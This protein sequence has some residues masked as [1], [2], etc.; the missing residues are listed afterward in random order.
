M[1]KVTRKFNYDLIYDSLE[2][3]NLPIYK[4]NSGPCLKTDICEEIDFPVFIV[5]IPK[6][7]TYLTAE[8]LKNLGIPFAGVHISPIGIV[9]H[10]F[11]SAEQIKKNPETLNAPMS[12]NIS[13]SLIRNGQ[14]CVGHIP[15]S[16]KEDLLKFKKIVTYRN[17][18]RNMVVSLTRYYGSIKSKI[19]GTSEESL[20]EFNKLKMSE[21]KIEMCLKLW[22]NNIS[23]L[24]R[25]M[26]PWQKNKDCLRISFESLTEEK[27]VIKIANFLDLDVSPER[28]KE[29]LDIATSTETPSSTGEHSDYRKYWSDSLDKLLKVYGI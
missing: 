1:L 15:Y 9:D 4:S 26:K 3:K 6:T 23:S 13:C 25:D 14:F 28:A 2:G 24:T 29:I 10:R 20:A 21:E 8:I 11:A 27:S 18:V 16:Y 12:L 5:S 17:E 22:G 19:P 7:G